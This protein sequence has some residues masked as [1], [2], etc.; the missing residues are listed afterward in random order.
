MANKTLF[1]SLVGKLIPVTDAANSE[2]APAYSLPPKHMLAQ[3]VMTGC[4]NGTFYATA[5]EQLAKVLEMCGKADAEFIAKLAVV[6]RKRGHMKDMP[7]LLAA[8]LSVKDGA[9]LK[10]IFPK[11]IDNG[12]MLRNFVQILR[13][14][15]VGRKSLGSMPKA[16]VQGWL[17]SAAEHAL[18]EASVGQ[19]PSLADVIKM[20]HPRPIGHAREA[21]YGY[22]LGKPHNE[23][24]LPETVK[25]YLAFKRSETKDVPKVPFQWL[26]SLELGKAGWSA[27]ARRAS[28]Q[29]TRMNLN[30]FMRHGVFEDEEL[31]KIVCDRLRDKDAIGKARVLPYQLLAAYQNAEA[32]LPGVIREALQDA[33]ETALANVPEVEGKVYVCPDVSGSMSSA[34]TGNRPGATSA[35]RCIDVAA[36][37]AAAMLRKNR[38]ARVLPFEQKV[39]DLALNPRDSVMTNAGRLAA[40]GGGGTNCSAPLALLNKEKAMGDLVV[41]ISD[42]ESWVDAKHGRGTETLLQWARFRERNP[43]ARLV[44]IDIQPNATT[45]ARG[46][47]DI[48]NVGG[49]SDQV[50]EVVDDFAAGRMDGNHWVSRIEEEVL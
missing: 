11:V 20:V 5:G 29:M 2:R 47:E 50:F 46:R 6:A 19:D 4:L 24:I 30:T 35:M 7:A 28:W 10:K 39:V 26:T 43:K 14:G 3:Y 18:L 17:E 48:L 21:L 49:F 42:N 41:F 44:C 13:S 27:V 25:G 23:T 40:I 36:L 31:V 33:M 12:K 15:V 9:L 38:G 16:L 22:L 32:K 37:V 34:V 8:F 1:A 45:Q